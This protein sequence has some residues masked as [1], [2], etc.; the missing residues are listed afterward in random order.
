MSH[1]TSRR[2]SLKRRSHP[3]EPVVPS[4]KTALAAGKNLNTSWK[5]RLIVMFESEPT[6][7]RLLS[8]EGLRGL[9]VLLVFFVHFHSIFESDIVTHPLTNQILGLLRWL[10]FCGVD[11]FFVISGFLIYG[12]LIRKKVHY[13]DFLWRRVCRIYPTFLVVFLIYIPISYVFPQ[14]SRIPRGFDGVLYLVENFFLLPG[15]LPIEPLVTVAWSL[16]YEFFFYLSIPLAV[17]ALRLRDWQPSHRA[18]LFC[19]LG[20]AHLGLSRI[21]LVGYPRMSMFTGGM[22]L[23]ELVSTLDIQRHIPRWGEYAITCLYAVALIAIGRTRM[24]Q[25]SLLS[26]R[27]NDGLVFGLILWFTTTAFVY[28]S[29]NY[30]GFLKGWFSWTPLRWLGNM[31]YS[32]YL[33]HGLVLHGVWFA[34]RVVYP[35]GIHSVLLIWAILPVAFAATV[36]CS[37][38]LYLAV[39]RP[40]SLDAK[41]NS[42]LEQMPSVK[43]PRAVAAEAGN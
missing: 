23:F 12:A 27:H 19:V 33:L 36:C 24:L 21:G 6:K 31:S 30:P 20:L 35:G 15:M 25:G 26:P 42:K 3:R 10:G 14:F 13:I 9:A 7:W 18:L 16:S 11:L 28:Y 4:L 22:L 38:I 40:L 2:K 32:Y 8:M 43:T 5:S 39:E 37:A 1:S 41:K 29:I 34:F 17:V